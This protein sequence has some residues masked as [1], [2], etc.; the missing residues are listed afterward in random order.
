MKYGM[1]VGS[2]AAALLLCAGAAV[3][4]PRGWSTD[5][6]GTRAAARAAGK[7]VLLAIVDSA[8]CYA[9][10]AFK[11]N[12]IDNE[13]W[14]DWREGNAESLLLVWWDRAEIPE[15]TWSETAFLF[16]SGGE[17]ASLSTPLV[18]VFSPDGML[19]VPVID[20][21]EGVLLDFDAFTEAVDERLEAWADVPSGALVWPPVT[22]ASGQRARWSLDYYGS[23]EKGFCQAVAGV[24]SD[25]RF[26]RS[27][28]DNRGAGARCVDVRGVAGLAGLHEHPAGLVGSR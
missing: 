19:A 2:I 16:S 17:S 12:V 5:Y 6:Q 8:N 11:R 27:I 10:R 14:A 26:G 28:G 20:N 24:G 4:A 15:R 25:C 1:T 23:R 9:S 7:H 22:Q 3:A 21:A 18:A 13:G